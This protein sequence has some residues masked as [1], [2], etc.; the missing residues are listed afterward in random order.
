MHLASVKTVSFV[1][2]IFLL[3]EQW[4]IRLGF[5]L[6]PEQLLKCWRLGNVFDSQELRDYL[7]SITAVIS[8][9]KLSA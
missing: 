7:L 6:K 3:L 5:L 4:V 1:C 2:Y 9:C 8:R